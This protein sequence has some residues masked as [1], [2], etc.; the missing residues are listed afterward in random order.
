MC[1]KARESLEGRGYIVSR[2]PVTWRLC[3]D[4]MWLYDYG[5]AFFVHT[6]LEGK[7]FQEPRSSASARSEGPGL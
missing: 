4:L 3:V 7:A 5:L 6:V 2:S 1:H